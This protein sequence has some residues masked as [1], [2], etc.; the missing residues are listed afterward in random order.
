MGVGVSA[1]GSVGKIG[2]AVG[3]G[4]A[5]TTSTVSVGRGAVGCAMLVAG[6]MADGVIVRVGVGMGIRVGV[7]GG[8]VGLGVRVER[9]VTVGSTP[10]EVA[11]GKA[12]VVAKG[13]IV[14]VRV[15]E[16]RGV[17]GV[18]VGTGVRVGTGVKVEVGNAVAG[19]GRTGRGRGTEVAPGTA[20]PGVPL[21]MM[22][23]PNVPM[24]VGVSKSCLLLGSGVL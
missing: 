1:T 16:G 4:E 9:G 7:L 21:S 13:V 11:V 10:S 22:T 6:G 24:G 17:P 14:G 8:R 12:V 5:G 20:V 2:T 18:F 3:V 23:S 15:A 19:R